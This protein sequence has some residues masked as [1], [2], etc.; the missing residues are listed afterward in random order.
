MSSLAASRADNFYFPPDWRP[1]YGGISKF[2][3]SK[4]ANQYEQYGI[5]RFELPF[6]GWC[7]KCSRHISKGTR[8]NAKKDKVGKYF[9]TILYSFTMKCASC[10]NKIVIKTNPQERTY[11]YAEG[12]RAMEQSYE[13]QPDDLVIETMSDDVKLQLTTNPMFKLQHENEDKK[14]AK[15]ANER[16]SSLMSLREDTFAK[17]YDMNSVLRKKNRAKKNHEIKMRR[18]G[19]K[20]HVDIPLLETSASD[21]I[22][23]KS[24][25][26]R[27]NRRYPKNKR[28]IFDDGNESVHSSN[29]LE[30]KF[31][32][33][34]V[35]GRKNE[36]SDASTR[37][38]DDCQSSNVA[39]VKSKESSGSNALQSLKFYD[40]SDDSTVS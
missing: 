1:E 12:I 18:E 25:I 24:V 39:S 30:M 29:A 22:G 23:A 11:D 19:K 7:L 13:T 32:L 9:S 6:D 27:S 2:Q 31:K 15:T 37:K 4:G 35:S 17:D 36:L 40:N 21:I 34:K 20:R 10:D 28:S 33:R 14:K 16:I 8:F 3:G 5:I 26:F 38:A